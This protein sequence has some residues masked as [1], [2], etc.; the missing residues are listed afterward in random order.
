MVTAYVVQISVI[1][2]HAKREPKYT[3]VISEQNAVD[4]EE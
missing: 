3:L 4:V 2:V 1:Y